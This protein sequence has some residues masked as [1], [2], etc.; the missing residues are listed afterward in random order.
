MSLF[1]YWSGGSASSEV[2]W[3]KGTQSNVNIAN[4]DIR[5]NVLQYLYMKI[6][7]HSHPSF[8]RF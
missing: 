6:T 3:A 8:L 7:S 2:A 4:I 1:S 5:L